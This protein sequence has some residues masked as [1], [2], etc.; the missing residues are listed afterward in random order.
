MIGQSHRKQLD[1]FAS[2]IDQKLGRD[3]GI[4]EVKGLS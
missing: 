4:F 3:T 2:N 1:R